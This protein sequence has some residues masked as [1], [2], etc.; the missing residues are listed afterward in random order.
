MLWAAS[1]NV[2][3]TH[4]DYDGTETMTSQ[5]IGSPKLK[6]NGPLIM[7][8]DSKTD[9][10]LA[11]RCYGRSNLKNQFLPLYSGNDFLNYMEGV[12]EGLQQMPSLVL[13]DVNMP[14]RSGFDV[15]AAV[16]EFTEFAETP[17]ITMLSNSGD[18]KDAQ[19]S[20]ELGADGFHTKPAQIIDY[21]TFFNSLSEFGDRP[22]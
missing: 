18:P 19:R 3:S 8:D 1:Y 7:V 17:P 21:V 10:Y 2:G 12:R 5:R 14:G 22:S 9:V 15:L 20:I 16:K 6:G 11:L 13:L 4:V